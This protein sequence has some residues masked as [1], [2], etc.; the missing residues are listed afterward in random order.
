VLGNIRTGQLLAQ[1]TRLKTY[2][3]HPMETLFFDSK[4]A[5]VEAYYRGETP[6]GWIEQTPIQWVVYSLYEKEFT[7]TFIPEPDLELVYQNNTVQIY[8]VKH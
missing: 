7:P 2:V 6:K 3:G 8:K 4:T 5:A 1:R